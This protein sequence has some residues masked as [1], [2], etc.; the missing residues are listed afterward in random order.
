M[1]PLLPPLTRIPPSH[2]GCSVL[3]RQ[4]VTAYYKNGVADNKGSVTVDGA[5]Y[6]YNWIYANDDNYRSWVDDLS[7]RTAYTLNKGTVHLLP[8]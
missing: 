3:R 5:K 8:G 2:G 1:P 4:A 7:C 6:G